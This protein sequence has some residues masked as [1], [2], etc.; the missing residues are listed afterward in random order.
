VVVNLLIL[1]LGTKLWSSGRT[2]YVLN[3]WAISPAPVFSYLIN[4][5]SFNNCVS[6]LQSFLLEHKS[7]GWHTLW[8]QTR[9]QTFKHVFFFPSPFFYLFSDT[10][11][12]ILSILSQ[13][14]GAS[15]LLDHNTW[16][17][18]HAFLFISPPPGSWKG[19]SAWLSFISQTLIQLS[20][21]FKKRKDGKKGERGKD[22]AIW[23]Q[24]FPRCTWPKNLFLPLITQPKTCNL[25]PLVYV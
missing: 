10:G 13:A 3:T 11:R 14:L 2:V 8:T 24:L 22:I 1:V 7:L 20:L 12:K 17:K 6:L 25:V 23:F 16:L 21:S 15:S 5:F 18:R 9:N 19:L 4:C